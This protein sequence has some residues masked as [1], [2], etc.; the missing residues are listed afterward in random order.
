ML[1]AHSRTDGVFRD[2]PYGHDLVAVRRC[3]VPAPYRSRIP[4]VEIR[5][6]AE[7]RPGSRPRDIL[8]VWLAGQCPAGRVRPP[9]SRG[10]RRGGS[11]RV[12]G[13]HDSGDRRLRL[14]GSAIA[15]VPT[16]VPPALRV[17]EGENG[18]TAGCE[19]S[20]ARSFS[21][22]DRANSIHCQAPSGECNNGHFAGNLI[23]GRVAL[24]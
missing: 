13:V 9:R 2:S 14:E 17:G 15:G 11:G 8:P 4:P 16:V 23:R 20:S 24:L 21:R 18:G 12:C 7:W 19:P 6:G 3:P 22:D 10:H 1:S 5:R